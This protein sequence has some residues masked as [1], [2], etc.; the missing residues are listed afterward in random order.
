MYA[1]RSYYDNPLGFLK[2]NQSTLVRYLA[3]LRDAWVDYGDGQEGLTRRMEERYHLSELFSDLD[4]IAEE[5]AE[6]FERI[7]KIVT[8]LR[9]FSRIDQTEQLE[10]FD[11]EKGLESTLVVAQ[12]EIKYVAEVEKAFSSVEP[13]MARGNELNQV[14]LNILVNAAQAIKSQG[15]S[16]KGHIRIATESLPGTDSEPAFLRITID[17]DV[18]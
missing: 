4:A 9:A 2:S 17:D 1:I 18:V 14:F 16:E 3:K 6:G 8:G 15:R 10:L 7:V 12:N 11:V 13:I 5:S